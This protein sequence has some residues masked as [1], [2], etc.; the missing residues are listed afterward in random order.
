MFR[1][2]LTPKLFNNI[3]IKENQGFTLIEL[4]VVVIII[5]VLSAVALPNLLQQVAKSRQ[6]E[7]KI[8]LGTIN[9]VQQGYRFETGTFTTIA[10]LPVTISGQYYTFADVG[11]AD[12]QGAVHIATVVSLLENELKDYSSAVGQAPSGAYIG[13]IC[14]Q[15]SAD[16]STLPIPATVSGGIPACTN[17][18]TS[19]F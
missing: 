12:A 5:G 16:G 6:A 7:A 18:T 13:R 8:N 11:T 17:G 19:I 9:R 1:Y 4:L 10:N 3:R 15:N 2:K 14:E